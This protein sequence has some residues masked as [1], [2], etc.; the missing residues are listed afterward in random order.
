M[1]KAFLYLCLIVGFCAAFASCKPSLPRDV[2]SKGKMTDILFDYHI[3]LAMAQSEDGG[4]EKN[5]LA[6]REA[7]LKKHDVTSADFDSSMVYYM[8][9]TELLHDV[10]KDLAERLDKE[11]VALGG[12]SAGNSDFDN[13]TSVG[14]TA[15]I[16]KEATSMVFSTDAGF[17]SRSFKIEAD[18]AF[19]KGDRFRLDF[20]SQFIFQ[21][22]MRDGV[23]L[24]A[25][26]FKNDSVAQTVVHI[27][28][29]QH[30]SVE[31]AD[32]D[33]LGR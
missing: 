10:Y 9:H 21:D 17:N 27:Q 15:N 13:L 3:A 31:L 2:L 28:S 32:N 8:R 14:D 19:H 29:A 5:S 25:V 23:A 1:K 11:A 24:L 7:V 26:Q 22:G 18:T 33:S 20:E 30:Y 16:W 4:S 12:N 6:Y